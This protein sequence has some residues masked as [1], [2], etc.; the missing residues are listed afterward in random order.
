M[1]EGDSW[2]GIGRAGRER[3]G[4]EQRRRLICNGDSGKRRGRQLLLCWPHI[5]ISTQISESAGGLQ[6]ILNNDFMTVPSN[7]PKEQKEICLAAGFCRKKLIRCN[8]QYTG[9]TKTP[10]YTIA[11]LLYATTW[12]KPQIS[13]PRDPSP[14]SPPPPPHPPLCVAHSNCHSSPK[15]NPKPGSSTT[16]AK[17]PITINVCVRVTKWPQQVVPKT[18]HAPLSQ[19][20]D[21]RPRLAERQGGKKKKKDNNTERAAEKERYDGKDS[22]VS[23]FWRSPSPDDFFSPPLFFFC[24]C[25]SLPQSV[26]QLTPPGGPGETGK[27]HRALIPGRRSLQPLLPLSAWRGQWGLTLS[28]R[29]QIAVMFSIFPLH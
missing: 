24:R 3:R 28:G 10:S 4:C 14:P 16:K 17:T 2:A 8:H 13:W 7:A 5:I 12:P 29:L 20:I 15:S 21:Q 19:T 27:W 11:W 6:L 9:Q 22:W 18:E 1:K 23:T 25:R 26:T